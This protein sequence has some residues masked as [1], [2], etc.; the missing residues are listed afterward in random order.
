MVILG[1]SFKPTEFLQH[2]PLCSIAVCFVLNVKKSKHKKYF[3]YDKTTYDLTRRIFD[4]TGSD[5]MTK[6][7][8]KL[9]PTSQL[10]SG[11]PPF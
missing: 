5:V 7:P 6:A 3:V 8:P 10:T 2:A 1:A 9:Q 11:D 4:N